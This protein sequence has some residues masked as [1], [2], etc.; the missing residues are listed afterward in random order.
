MLCDIS[1]CTWDWVA[2]KLLNARPSL[3]LNSAL[4]LFEPDFRL[5]TILIFYPGAWGAM[6]GSIPDLQF[7][8]VPRR[9]N[10]VPTSVV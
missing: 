3:K 4:T 2:I 5:R 8:N 1:L 10:L 9:L 6:P 7:V